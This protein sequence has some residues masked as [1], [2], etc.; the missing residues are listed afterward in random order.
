MNAITVTQ[1]LIDG[2]GSKFKGF[3]STISSAAQ[4]AT[5]KFIE[6]LRVILFLPVSHND[7]TQIDDCKVLCTNIHVKF[8]LMERLS[9]WSAEFRQDPGL[10][11]IPQFYSRILSYPE[12]AP[13]IPTR[14]L[15]SHPVLNLEQRTMQILQ[16]IELANNNAQMLVE[17]VSFADSE[18]EVVE[19]NVLIK[20]F[21]SKCLTLHRGIQMYLN[22]V[23]ASTTPNEVCLEGLLNSNQELISALGTYNQMME[24]S[25]LNKATR[26]AIT[27]PE[28]LVMDRDGAGVGVGAG[29]TRANTHSQRVNSKNTCFSHE[30][31]IASDPFADDLYRV[32]DTSDIAIEIKNGKRPAHINEPGQ[33]A[34]SEEEQKLIQIIKDQSLAD[35]TKNGSSSSSSAAPMTTTVVLPIVVSP[36]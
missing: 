23:T 13:F 32:T 26:V 36:V 29:F 17:A 8:R 15:P 1:G 16:D 11:A 33:D 2:C 18:T 20:E 28:L 3:T 19:E 35:D 6:D 31:T 21:H 27:E 10:V 30:T 24:Q 22:E 5:S 14:A 9:A 4:L 34:I 25:N 12:I 7:S